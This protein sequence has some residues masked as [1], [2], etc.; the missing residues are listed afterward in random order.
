[1]GSCKKFGFYF[2]SNRKLLKGCNWRSDTVL[3]TPV[4]CVGEGRTGCHCHPG[5]GSGAQ[6]EGVESQGRAWRPG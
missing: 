1:M 6:V 5:G 3:A 2:M 4:C